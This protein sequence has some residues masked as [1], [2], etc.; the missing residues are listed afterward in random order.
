MEE[1]DVKKVVA[2]IL[3]AALACGLLAGCGEKSQNA[4]TILQILK[5]AG[6]PISY[7]IIYTDE[8][9]PNG[10][11]EKAYRQ[12]ANFAD[13]SIEPTYRED[14]PT[15]GTIEIFDSQ[16]ALDERADHLKG[17]SSLG[18]YAY[19]IT[20][21]LAL[22]RLSEFFTVEQAK[23]YA[24]A[25]GE[26]L[27]IIS[28]PV[29]YEPSETSFSNEPVNLDDYPVVKAKLNT[30]IDLLANGNDFVGT[31]PQMEISLN[32]VISWEGGVTANLS[33]SADVL[34]SF[35][36]SSDGEDL[37]SFSLQ[38]PDEVSA[39]DFAAYMVRSLTIPD[40]GFS[41]EDFDK[42]TNAYTD[43]E[44]SVSANGYTVKFITVLNTIISITKD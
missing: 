44:L 9:D 13:S 21:G 16:K 20:S 41:L 18:G 24:N 14:Q 33:D 25:L 35:V 31:S 11:G 4:A 34:I 27:E 1:C 5:D 10:T 38:F 22:I 7:E 43:K 40:F 3:A 30:Y 17:W 26:T 19:M 23:E 8:N 15:S 39:D 29:S 37:L 32:D 28:D 6:L 2:L 42:I 36:F 12:K